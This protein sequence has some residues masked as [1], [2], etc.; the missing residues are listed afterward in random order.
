M[1]LDDAQVLRAQM[2][3]VCTPRARAAFR[4]Q[5]DDRIAPPKPL[6]RPSATARSSWLKWRQ[7]K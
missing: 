6:A 4:Q 1:D 5:V 7:H 3:E 2:F